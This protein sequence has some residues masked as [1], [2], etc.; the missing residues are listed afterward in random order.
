[1]NA[2]KY[3]ALL[4]LLVA[5]PLAAQQAPAQPELLLQTVRLFRGDKQTLVKAFVEVPYRLLRVGGDQKLHYRMSVTVKDTAGQVLMDQGWSQVATPVEEAASAAGLEILEFAVAPGRYTLGIRVTDSVSGTVHGDSTTLVGFQD[6]PVASDLVVSRSVRSAKPEDSLP[7]SGE[8]RHGNLVIAATPYLRLPLEKPEL[9]YVLEA[10]SGKA[11]TATITAQ[12]SNDSGK[13]LIQGRPRRL[14]VEGGGSV[15]TGGMNLAGLPQGT[16]RLTLAIQLGGRETTREAAFAVRNLEV[17]IALA[18][19]NGTNPDEAYFGGMTEAQLDSAQAPLMYIAQS[20]ELNSYKGLSLQAK[21]RWLTQ[22]WNKRDRTPNDGVNQVRQE[23]Y[24]L[25]NL[26]D[27]QYREAGRTRVQGW[28]TD[29]GR[30]FLRFGKPDEVWRR[31]E[32]GRTPALEVWRYTS[33]RARWFIFGDRSRLGTYL[34]VYSNEV[35]EPGKPDWSE[36]LGYYGIQA[37][38]DYL[39]VN[40]GLRDRTPR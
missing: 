15:L 3:A 1:M 29:R 21:Q 13:V 31:P 26:A 36:L 7:K 4:G 11:D 24:A 32:E 16:Y 14:A 39:G 35:T 17:P 18:A 38:E 2:V 25:V 5:G 27:E 22:F 12:V 30:I 40:L 8:W 9:Y 37:V 6:P 34:L 20:G 33:G 28:R 10:Y 23:F 19:G